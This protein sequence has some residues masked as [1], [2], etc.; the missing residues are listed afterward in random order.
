MPQKQFRE[1]LKTIISCNLVNANYIEINNVIPLHLTH[2][3]L[4]CTVS[5]TAVKSPEGCGYIFKANKFPPSFRPSVKSTAIE[6]IKSWDEK[7]VNNCFSYMMT[8]SRTFVKQQQFVFVLTKVKNQETGKFNRVAN[9]LINQIENTD[10]VD[11]VL[12]YIVQSLIHLRKNCG[13]KYLKHSQYNDLI[14]IVVK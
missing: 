12:D 4:S 11:I 13:I 5:A 8:S 10:R 7:I 3:E 9:I 6:V 1:K 14:E 2:K